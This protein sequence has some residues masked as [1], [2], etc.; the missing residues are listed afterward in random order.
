VLLCSKTGNYT[1][2]HEVS[3]AINV[4][5]DRYA[6]IDSAISWT[7][8]EDFLRDER[9]GKEKRGLPAKLTLLMYIKI[10]A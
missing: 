4:L 6:Q 7:M 5:R 10:K 9:R 2:I 3:T 8:T 1:N